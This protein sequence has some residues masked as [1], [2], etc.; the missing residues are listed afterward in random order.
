MQRLVE[1]RRVIRRWQQLLTVLH[2]EV[3]I[4]DVKHQ[5]SLCVTEVERVTKRNRFPTPLQ[6]VEQISQGRLAIVGFFQVGD[7][8]QSRLPH[9]E[10]GLIE[11]L[12]LLLVT[13]REAVGKQRLDM[14]GGQGVELSDMF[15]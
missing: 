3:S 4:G 12:G 11:R 9:H 8:L 10:A 13:P 7:D 14:R 2:P 6:P 1:A 5:P 15:V